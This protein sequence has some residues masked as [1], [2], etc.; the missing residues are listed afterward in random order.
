M[1]QGCDINCR[2]FNNK[3]YPGINLVCLT[4]FI[5]CGIAVNIYIPL[6][7]INCVNWNENFNYSDY[8]GVIYKEKQIT[9]R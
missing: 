8:V 3:Q 7:N 6:P 1:E 4:K 9:L 2:N 5:L